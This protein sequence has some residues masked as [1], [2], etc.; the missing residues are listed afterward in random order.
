MTAPSWII[1][2]L[3]NP[4]AE[5]AETRHNIGWMVVEALVRK[6]G[7][8]W[9]QGVGPWLEASVTIAGEPVLCILPLTYM[10]RSGEAVHA[11]QRLTGVPTDRIVVVLDELNFPLGRLHLKPS[12]SD[13]GHNGLRSVI[14]LL[15]TQQIP[16]LRCGIGRNFQPGQ[17]ADYVLSPFESHEWAERDRMVE[18][19]V[20][21]LEYLVRYGLQRAMSLTNVATPPHAE[22]SAVPRAD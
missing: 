16:R 9:R 1:A 14:A 2:G 11:V 19:A 12:G 17:M 6:Y 20:A 21:V 5:Y 22:Q 7:G 15:G 18:R 10:N 3:G 8:T 4:G 13:G